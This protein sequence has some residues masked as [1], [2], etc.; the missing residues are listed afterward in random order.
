MHHLW[1][2][3]LGYLIHPKIPIEKEN[4]RVADIGSG[5]GIWLIDA[6]EILPK[7]AQLHGLDIS[8]DATPAVGVLPANMTLR[9]WNV[10]DPVPE[11]LIGVF[12][13]IQVR[14]FVFVLL[15]EEVPAVVEKLG[16]SFLALE[17]QPETANILELMNRFKSQDP[18]LNATWIPDLPQIFSDQGLVAVEGNT[19]ETPAHWAFLMHECGLIMHELVARQTG[20]EKMAEEVRELL[21]R[22]LSD[23]R[24]EVHIIVTKHAVIGRK[25]G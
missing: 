10:K 13:I 22:V 5:T 7:S 1:T 19:H 18:R 2:K 9:H 4:L 24:E 25:P 16:K 15:R 11:D 14:F 21:P 8:F 17:S 6:S 20:N 12:D 23:T 3:S